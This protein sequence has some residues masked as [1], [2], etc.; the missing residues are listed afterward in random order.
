MQMP[1]ASIATYLSPTKFPVAHFPNHSC[2]TLKPIF[3]RLLLLLI[4]WLTLSFFSYNLNL[5]FSC[6]LSIS[7]FIKFVLMALSYAAIEEKIQLFSWDFPIIDISRFSSERFRR[8]KTPY[9]C[10]LP[11]WFSNCSC[12]SLWSYFVSAVTGCLI[13]LSLLF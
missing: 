13:S 10:L 4:M 7:A 8:L 1:F 6:V 12:L 3:T 11:Q 2:Q 9:I 5:L